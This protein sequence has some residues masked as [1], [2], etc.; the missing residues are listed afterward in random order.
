M[1]CYEPDQALFIP[2]KPQD[3]SGKIK[4]VAQ[5]SVLGL[6]QP[7]EP[8]N[9]YSFGKRG[10]VSTDPSEVTRD[11]KKSEGSVLEAEGPARK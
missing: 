5:R 9:R 3:W 4:T 2:R 8:V 6:F 1:N 11:A 10:K 7:Q